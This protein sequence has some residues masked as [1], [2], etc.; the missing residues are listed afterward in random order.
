MAARFDLLTAPWLPC[1]RRAGA[2]EEIS[3]RELLAQPRDWQD[4]SCSSPLTYAALLRLLVALLQAAFRGPERN[5]E[6]AQWLAEGWDTGRLEDYLARWADRFDLFSPEHPFYQDPA[7]TLETADSIARL[8]PELASGNN[9]TLFDHTL[10]QEP[11]ALTPAEAAR[12]AVTHQLFGLG[13]GKGPRSNY[14]THAYAS[15]APTATGVTLLVRGED[16]F[17]TLVLNLVPPAQRP[18]LWGT[19]I[20][21]R[22]FPPPGRRQPDGLL[23]CLTWPNRSLRL[24][25]EEEAGRLVVR[26]VYTAQGSIFPT[27]GSW[28]DP[29]FPFRSTKE[30]SVPLRMEA[31]RALWRDSGALLGFASRDEAR[32]EGTVAEQP[33][34]L[35]QLGGL[36]NPSPVWSLRA[37]GLDFNQSRINLWRTDSLELPAAL[38]SEATAAELVG[39]LAHAIQESEKVADALEDALDGLAERLLSPNSDVPGAREKADRKQVTALVEGW[40]VTALYWQALDGPYRD[41]L[42]RLARDPHGAVASWREKLEDAAEQAFTAAC[43]LAGDSGRALRARI[44]AREVV[45]RHWRFR[46]KSNKERSHDQG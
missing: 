25:P 39:S 23:D 10:D 12:W 18:A 21:E 40:R 27:D 45:T 7:F 6:R 4:L 3:L 16:L 33:L 8:A 1:R 19:A 24:L 35:K 36:P 22:D 29:Y 42:D 44:R 38:L 14:G 2:V 17:E 46:A 43:E 37:V 9:A 31:G 30:G 26:R 13:G 15:H 41:L 28:R 11:P 34:V 32:R 20:W 5:R